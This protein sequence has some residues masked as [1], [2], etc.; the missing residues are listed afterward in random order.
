MLAVLF[1]YIK[2]HCT[3]RFIKWSKTQIRCRGVKLERGHNL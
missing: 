3:I 2:A 1:S